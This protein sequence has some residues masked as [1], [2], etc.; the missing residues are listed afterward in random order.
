MTVSQT[1]NRPSDRG[2]DERLLAL[3]EQYL[4]SI[5]TDPCFDRQRWI[6]LACQQHPSLAT[7]LCDDASQIDA[8]SL[9]AGHD[10]RSSPLIDGYSI[11]RR[12][13]HGGAGVVFE[14]VEEKL[15]RKVA[16]KVFP[17]A[18]DRETN[19]HAR[20]IIEAQAAAR[21]DHP[22]IV[23]IYCIG[24]DATCGE[25][26]FLSMKLID[27]LSIDR[28]LETGAIDSGTAVGWAIAAADAIAEA[29]DCGIIHRDIKPSNL[30]VDR[31]NHLW[32]TDFGLAR[33]APGNAVAL[34]QTG[35]RVGTMAYMSPEQ[36]S[37]V[38]VDARAD[39]Y[40]LGLTLFELLTGRRA[41][42]GETIGQ[43]QNAREHSDS[44]S[45][46]AYNPGID[47]DLDLIVAKAT[48]HELSQRYQSAREFADDMRRYQNREPIL[49]TR[50]SV[51]TRLSK[52]MRRH[53]RIVLAVAASIVLIVAAS[54]VVLA[55]L[56][57]ANGR[58]R[59]ALAS[60]Q[61]NL[62]RTEEILD[63]FGL[64]AAE[65]LRDVEGAEPV[66]RELLKQTLLY[67][68]DYA[69]R[70]QGGEQFSEQIAITYFKAAQIIDEI[71]AKQDAIEN[72]ESAA[73]LFAKATG[74]SELG[75]TTRALTWN[76]LAVLR[77]ELGEKNKAI[78]LYERVLDSSLAGVDLARTYG[79]YAMLRIE[80]REYTQSIVLIEKGLAE[81]Q[82]QAGQEQ[83][84]VR[85]MLLSQLSYVL[86]TKQSTQSLSVAER[87][88]AL[89]QS[90]PR[91]PEI[92]RM[93]A[94]ARAN[95]AALRS[96]DLSG[97]AADL[98]CATELLLSIRDSQSHDRTFLTQVATIQNDLGRV[99][100]ENGFVLEAIEEFER[101]EQTLVCLQQTDPTA[102]HHTVSLAGVLHNLG[103]AH[104]F[105]DSNEKAGNYFHRSLD[106][107]K[108]LAERSSQMTDPMKV[109]SQQLLKQTLADLKRVEQL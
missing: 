90:Q 72:Y 75:R 44:F 30:M 47:R 63:R 94:T 29:H 53:R 24:G 34:T 106:L 22:N 46:R 86:Q 16:L 2:N 80:S 20:F 17:A 78:E 7:E 107:Q 95:R 97:A 41:I 60:S 31:S 11:I 19:A 58:T 26:C 77:A 105:T 40:A 65:K 68:E 76:N 85:A 49:A 36:A 23:P 5:E 12:L 10:C 3:L 62:Q 27:G 82:Q 51:A 103:R 18:I 59:Q 38:P 35:D 101:A 8:L 14:A 61:S 6:E 13:G 104:A 89:L 50:P 66:R 71:G 32:V 91:T 54:W 81:I 25:T 42:A 79:N 37:G 96:H 92:I 1:A 52:W 48:A 45:P 83:G 69:R 73:Q 55:Q 4:E 64:L 33:L 98:K 100:I 109:T 88:I 87:A 93:L 43:V 21:L 108:S 84:L 56:A 57:I 74:L 67:Y 15:Q 102:E 28:V 39:V 9:L 70:I 99:L